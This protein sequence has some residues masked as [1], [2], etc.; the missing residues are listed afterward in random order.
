M[1]QQSLSQRA[2]KSEFVGIASEL[3]ILDSMRKYA[4]PDRHTPM[5]ILFSVSIF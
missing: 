1:F 3:S 5:T 2:I 4:G